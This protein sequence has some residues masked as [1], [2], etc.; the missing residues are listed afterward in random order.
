M[1]ERYDS[2][3]VARTRERR[4]RSPPQAGNPPRAHLLEG[5]RDRRR[6]KFRCRQRRV[7]LLPSHRKR[8]QPRRPEP[9]HDR[10][11]SDRTRPPGIDPVSQRDD[12][13]RLLVRYSSSCTS[14][15]TPRGMQTTSTFSVPHALCFT[16]RGTYTTTPL[17]SS[18]SSSSRRIRP[19]PSST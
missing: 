3:R 6:K 9:E 12:R 17:W 19:W 5:P 10:P 7:Q 4:R 15:S 11:D 13:A 14:S 1:L 18:I 16:P 8:R 2:S